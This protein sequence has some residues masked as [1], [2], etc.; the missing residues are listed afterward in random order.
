M[1][2]QHEDYIELLNK[3]FASRSSSDDCAYRVIVDVFKTNPA[4]DSVSY[5]GI[6]DIR[7]T[8][9]LHKIQGDLR[10]FPHNF[11]AIV[12]DSIMDIY[13]NNI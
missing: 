9:M 6:A 3:L 13:D 7:V 2:R 11:T 4:F 1:I 8:L 5:M 10:P 12:N